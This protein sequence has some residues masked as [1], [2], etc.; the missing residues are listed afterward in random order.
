MLAVT[1]GMDQNLLKKQIVL[2]AKQTKYRWLTKIV[3]ETVGKRLINLKHQ[4]L[5]GLHMA[6]DFF[7]G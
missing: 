1:K 6:S 3:R 4:A 2:T 5:Q 7:Y